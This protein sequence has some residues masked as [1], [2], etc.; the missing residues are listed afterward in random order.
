M[1]K[2]IIPVIVNEETSELKQAVGA[3]D[4]PVEINLR[5]IAQSAAERK[6]R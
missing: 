6:E 3:E 5:T 4:T 1:P 2:N